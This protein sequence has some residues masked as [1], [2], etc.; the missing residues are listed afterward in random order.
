MN[1]PRLRVKDASVE[2]G[3][4]KALNEVSFDVLPGEI[5][6]VLGHNGAGKSTLFNVISGSLRHKQG[7]IEVDGEPL[8]VHLTPEVA[9][10]AGVAVIHQEPALAPN[11]SVIDNLFLRQSGAPKTRG[12]ARRRAREVLKE[13]G[14]ESLDLDTRIEATGLGTRQQVDLARGMLRGQIKVLMLDEP[15][16]ALGRAETDYLH[17]LIR[18]LASRGVAV[19]YVSH[20]LPDI[21]DVCTR[22]MVMRAGR[23]VVD[24]EIT[25]FDGPSLNQ[26]LAP[27]IKFDE[28][29][30][31]R[32]GGEA[33]EFKF[34][35]TQMNCSAG[36][37]TGLFGMA[38]GEQFQILEELFGMGEPAEVQIGR[39]LVRIGNPYD[40]IRHGIHLVPSDR[41]RD[42]L[43]SGMSAKDTVFLPWYRG[44]RG[45]GYWLSESTG[46]YE[47]E[48][49][50][51][52]LNILGPPS[53]AP[54]D[55]FS[56]GNRQKHLIARWAMVRDAKVLLLAQPTQGVDVAARL[57][58]MRTVRAV[59][60][61]GIPV[62]VASAEA[63][64]I[65]LLCDEAYVVYQNHLKFAPRSRGYAG[66]L[67]AEL[68]ALAAQANKE[69]VSVS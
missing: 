16:A 1:T 50:R 48:K 6:G 27:G 55:Q 52:E 43:V 10:K 41:E 47:Y 33:V 67:T 57:D 29:E 5:V 61:Q 58:I 54:I 2:F 23:L 21:L 15:T 19:L 11:L 7:K 25:K 32:A 30:V 9:A 39:K 28:F 17:A 65:E 51:G 68:L 49:V 42:G 59:A 3:A 24:D 37:V 31:G 63:D 13:V 64:E 26:A 35:G 44:F 36:R 4:T 60:R 62:V 56:G 38:A 12:E 45:R 8:P 66:E 14:A 53:V 20:R 69:T 34:A 40:A 22:V 46:K 18:K